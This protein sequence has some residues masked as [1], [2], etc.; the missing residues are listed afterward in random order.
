MADY[1]GVTNTKLSMMPNLAARGRGV[2]GARGVR[3]GFRFSV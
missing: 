3:L 2:K 1:L